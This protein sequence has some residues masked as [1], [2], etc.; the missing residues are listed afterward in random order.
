MEPPA[1]IP[2]ELHEEDAEHERMKR[3]AADREALLAAVLDLP[4]PAPRLLAALRRHR[5]LTA[6]RMLASEPENGVQLTPYDPDFHHALRAFS[7]VRRQYRNTLK[8]LAE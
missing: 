1:A 2:E 3:L 7:E 4:E 6:D 5:D 8:K